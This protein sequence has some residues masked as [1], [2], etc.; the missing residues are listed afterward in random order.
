MDSTD[1]WSV[2]G[3]DLDV[4][5]ITPSIAPR[6]SDYVIVK[7]ILGSIAD[8]SNGVVKVASVTMIRVQNTTKVHHERVIVSLNTDG[9]RLFGNGSLQLGD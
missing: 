6:V 1:T 8:S 2:N 5:F 4:A 9:D 3:S 7:S